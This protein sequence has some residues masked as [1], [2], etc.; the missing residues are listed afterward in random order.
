MLTHHILAVL[1]F[2]S[3]LLIQFYFMY[4]GVIV[5]AVILVCPV[6]LACL[7]SCYMISIIYYGTN[8]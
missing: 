6:P 2:I 4:Y 3:V 7:L 8:K 5:S 1:V